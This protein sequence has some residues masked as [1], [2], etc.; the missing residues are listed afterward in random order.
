MFD[1]LKGFIGKTI[2]NYTRKYDANW[3]VRFLNIAHKEDLERG[4]T[5]SDPMAQH[6][7]INIAVSVRSKNIA[8]APFRIYRGDDEVTTGPVFDLFKNVNP[9]MSRFQLW[10]ATN[11]WLDVRGECIWLFNDDYGV[12]IPQEIY[13]VDPT[14][15]E[16]KLSK[17]KR[18]IVL[19]I[20]KQGS[21]EIPYTP[22]ELIHFYV[23]NKWNYYRGVNP[24]RAISQEI[25]MDWLANKSNINLLRHSSVPDG[26][27][28][29]EDGSISKEQATE[30]RDT[31]E[32][33]HQG[34]DRSHRISVLGNGMKYQNITLTNDDM[35]Y[36]KMKEWNRQTIL[37]KYGVNPR[38]V[39][40]S[41][42][43]SPLSGKDTLEQMKAF[44]N[45]T[46][47]PQIHF[48]QDK[49]ETDFFNRF[50]KDL[51]CE[52]DI[53]AIPEL[54][55]D[56]DKRY[57]RYGEAATTGLITINEAREKIGL[58]PV[59]WGDTW[60]KP[61]MLQP[62]EETM[63]NV[64][65]APPALPPPKKDIV[66]IDYDLHKKEKTKVSQYPEMYKNAHWWKMAR[67][68]ETIEGEFKKALKEWFHEQRKRALLIIASKA[69]APYNETLELIQG[70]LFEDSYWLTEERKLK[71]L[72]EKHF[73]LGMEFTNIQLQELFKDLGLDIAES[74]NIF[75]TGA[76][77][78]LKD[79]VNKGNLSLITDTVK[80]DLRDKIGQAI[81]EGLSERQTAD[82][83][84]GVYNKAGNRAA[85]I[86]RTELGGVINDSRFEGIKSVGFEY[87]SWLSARD[88]HVRHP[89]ESEYD[90][91]Y[92][93][94]KVKIGEKFYCG[95]IY[96]NDPNGEPGNVINCRCITLPE[97]KG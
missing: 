47:V 35:Q 97:E 13:P 23:W 78:K 94:E 22:D 76:L 63:L 68:E 92:D 45:L 8:R 29:A 9:F 18:E 72:A 62:V 12:G 77:T 90:H 86:A 95:L 25:N 73:I 70:E 53:S 33:Q 10:E 50:A 64:T 39:S 43:S 28:S 49:M 96:P 65:P 52:F 88:G 15:F 31:W 17:N 74:F 37:A 93:G 60:F 38:I 75:E 57:A 81:K 26:V 91:T 14:N 44:W 48:L 6:A 67:E 85:T 40:A 5:V 21:E 34:A 83:V 59:P 11:S 2:V 24:C 89:P 46:L 79:R 80:N 20:Y 84:R 36:F 42:Q 41:E 3:F 55:E 56:E 4:A 61:M 54:Q 51:R 30:I 7:W 27:L 1:K 32:K 19:W 69:K 66:S 82:L 71:D 16:Q 87:H 58:D